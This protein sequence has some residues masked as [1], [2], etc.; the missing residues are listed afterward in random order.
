MTDLFVNKTQSCRSPCL[1]PFASH[2]FQELK[3]ETEGYVYRISSFLLHFI[4]PLMLHL[5][6][7]WVAH[8]LMT[9]QGAW[10][11]VFWSFAAGY[12]TK[13]LALA[14]ALC[15]ASLDGGYMLQCLWLG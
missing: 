11:P 7:C 2:L 14:E 9:E 1:V 8:S 12:S 3:G 4:A 13:A 15:P 10:S 6:V 5:H